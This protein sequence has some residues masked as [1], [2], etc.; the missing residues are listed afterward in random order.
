MSE[1]TP[2]GWYPAPHANNELRY[3]DGASWH[4]QVPAP[5]APVPVAVLEAPPVGAPAAPSRAT[6]QGLAIA[7]LIVG[8]VAFLTGLVPWLG[9]L[10]GV[11]AVLLAV[12][13]LK[14]KQPRVLAF[15]GLAL[16]AIAALTG[17]IVAIVF[18]AALSNPTSSGQDEIVVSVPLETSV[19]QTAAPAAEPAATATPAPSAA[20]QP[21]AEP[22][23]AKP[24]PAKPAAPA[25]DLGSATNP[26]PQPYVAKGIFGGEKYSLSASVVDANANALVKEWNQFNSDAPAGFKYVVVQLTMTGI[27]PDGVEPSLAEWDLSL[28][29]AEGNRYDSEFLV[30]GDGMSSMSD[31]PTLYPGSS[32]TGVTAYIVP[33]AAQSF[34]IYDNGNFISF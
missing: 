14:N 11:G 12:F 19:E 23:P 9:L 10:L 20:E 31:G 18:G 32:F 2:A 7:A 3:W 30:L 4:D 6:P 26:Y 33:E 21:A 25:A 34:L 22:E 28:A 15:I 13:A 24:E 1:S 5:A 17:L 27:D 8:I 16:G 29:T